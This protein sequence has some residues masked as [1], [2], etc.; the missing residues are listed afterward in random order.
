[1]NIP[2]LTENDSYENQCKEISDFC[3]SIIKESLVKINNTMSSFYK[4]NRF[5]S[6]K[7]HFKIHC[8]ILIP[9]IAS[10]IYN[11]HATL[12]FN[13][14]QQDKSISLN[15][16]T[17]MIFTAVKEEISNYIIIMR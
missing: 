10:N 1:M 14:K 8:S 6:D 13:D 2:K 5:I 17:D 3:D 4:K 7:E 9:I 12:K 11:V 16:L 15:S